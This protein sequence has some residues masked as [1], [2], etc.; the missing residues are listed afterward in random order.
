MNNPPPDRV[1]RGLAP[2]S[3][4]MTACEVLTWIGLGDAQPKEVVI[5]GKAEAI[6]AQ[7]LQADRRGLLDV[8]ERGVVSAPSKNLSIIL[9]RAE[10]RRGRP[11]SVTELAVELRAEIERDDLEDMQL[12]QATAELIEALRGGLLKAYGIKSD[13]KGQRLD[14]AIH[15]EVPVEVFI[16][17]RV[18]ICLWD[19]IGPD[20]EEPFISPLLRRDSPHYSHVRFETAT[21]LSLWS[22]SI[23]GTD[24]RVVN[25]SQASAAIASPDHVRHIGY[26]EWHASTTHGRHGDNARDIIARKRFAMLDKDAAETEIA[27]GR[28][29][30]GTMDFA[31]Q[32]GAVGANSSVDV[33]DLPADWTLLECI[34]WIMFRDPRVVRDIAPEFRDG[35]PPCTLIRLRLDWAFREKG[36]HTMIGP[37]SDQAEFDILTRLRAGKLRSQGSRSPGGDRKWMEAVEWRGL[38][39]NGQIPGILRAEPRQDSGTVWLGTTIPREDMLREFPAVALTIEMR[40]LKYVVESDLSPS[41]P[42]KLPQWLTPMETMAW[43]VSRDARIVADPSS[44]RNPRRSLIV[45]HE[46]PSGKKLSGKVV[47]PTGMSLMWLD[48]FAAV[49]GGDPEPTA[50][51]MEELLTAL[52]NGEIIAKALWAVTGESQNIDSSEW[53]GMELDSPPE[54]HKMLV[55]YKKRTGDFAETPVTR[56]HDVLFPRETLMELWLA[57]DAVSKTSA[58]YAAAKTESP[59]VPQ[60]ISDAPSQRSRGRRPKYR[61]TKI[62]TSLGARLHSDGIPEPGDG[63]QAR[64]EKWVAEQFPPDS[65]PSESVIRDRVAQVIAKHKQLLEGEA[66]K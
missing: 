52:E 27:E 21:V 29:A 38:T 31:T 33:S 15:Q 23:K 65:C 34:A 35:K 11:V 3:V 24:P 17:E 45:D 41:T 58:P 13:P 12:R 14:G 50:Q 19:L 16:N 9:E 4:Y 42:P 30:S 56:W 22:S 62:L 26:S 44:K 40:G 32:G 53:R 6:S 25:R 7:W 55:L 2:K 39:L 37:N 8:L 36:G 59:S 66:G 28:S 10:R 60:T 54:N 61:W 49:E 1:T 18:T 47:L 57:F 48:R 20:W 43:I 46:L 5:N 51:A 63:G 64:Y